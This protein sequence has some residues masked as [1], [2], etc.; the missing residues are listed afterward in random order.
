MD[1]AAWVKM[2]D[3]SQCN[4][5]QREASYIKWETHMEFKLNKRR[6]VYVWTHKDDRSRPRAYLQKSKV[7]SGTWAVSIPLYKVIQLRRQLGYRNL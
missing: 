3:C 4:R 6:N 7:Q 1:I 2:L 5:V